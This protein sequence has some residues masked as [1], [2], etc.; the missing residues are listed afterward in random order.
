[1]LPDSPNSLLAPYPSRNIRLSAA[2]CAMGFAL[3][4][5]SE[6]ATVVVDFETKQPVVT[7]WHEHTLPPDAPVAKTF[8]AIGKI[9]TV[10]HV[11]IWW[12]NPGKYSIEGYDDALSAMRS[13]FEARQWLIGVIKGEHQLENARF[14]KKSIVTE[15]LHVASV[16]KGCGF[17][18]IGFE[19][20]NAR[21]ARFV[22]SNQASTIAALIERELNS[23]PEAHHPRPPAPD[24]CV[25]W[26]LW[27]LKY[28]DWLQRIVRDPNCIPMIEKRDG[29]RV[30]RISSAMPKTLRREFTRRF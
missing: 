25:D 4:M 19:K 30:C 29:E 12:A 15:S 9:L 3:R 26:M 14:N 7:F 6:P 10:A 21:N 17:P 20:V 23:A 18:L 16:I 8:A 11:G 5:D 1:M 27:A 13:V 2:L 28:R 22:F 24:P